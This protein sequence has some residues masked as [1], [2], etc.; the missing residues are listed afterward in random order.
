MSRIIV[1]LDV[2]TLDQARSLAA[3]LADEVAGFKVGLELITGVGPSVIGAI[4]DLGR[5][6]FADVKLHDIPN[7]VERAASR[8][9]GAGARWLTVHGSGGVEMV[10]AAVR[11]MGGNGVLT[12]TVLTSLGG[13]DLES[14][15][16]A[17]SLDDQVVRLARL[18][19]K[20]GAEGAVCA[21]G[22]IGAIK[23]AGIGLRL[24]TPGLRLDTSQPDDQKRIATPLSAAEA[25][26]DFLIIGRPITHSADP[27]RT[28]REISA[29]ISRFD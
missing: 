10:Q 26:A 7:T 2:R 28:A 29:S 22:E 9:A 4:A 19:E 13:E 1:A 14:I 5:P 17:S 24:F 12:V 27:T 18:G 15:G 25:G 6:V 3:P 11:G 23:E 16:V 8:I 20:G 21:P